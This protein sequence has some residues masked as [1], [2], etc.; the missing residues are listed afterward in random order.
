MIAGGLKY[1]LGFDDYIV[2]A[3]LIYVVIYT[4][5]RAIG[6]CYS[7]FSYTSFADS[8]KERV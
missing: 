1:G 2:G 7:L 6:H 4:L 8:G 5:L 3:I